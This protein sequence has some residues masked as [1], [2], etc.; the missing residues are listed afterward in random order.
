MWTNII[1]PTKGSQIRVNRGMYYHHGI[2]EDDNTI[3]HFASNTLGH[4]TD[5]EYATVCI[6]TLDVFLNGGELEVREYNEEELNKKRSPDE[7]IE[8]AKSKLGEGGYDI[9]NNNCE[10]F[11]NECV[12]G[13]KSSNQVDEVL[14]FLSSLFK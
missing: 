4:E 3:Y 14:S 8:F 7:I 2:Y 1:K 12:F 9:V 10:H 6:T 5:P 11:S 13:K